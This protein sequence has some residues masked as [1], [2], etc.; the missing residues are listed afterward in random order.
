MGIFKLIWADSA[1][2]VQIILPDGVEIT[3]PYVPKAVEPF[4]LSEFSLYHS[5][6]DKGCRHE[7]K[8]VLGIYKVYSNCKHCGIGKEVAEGNATP[9]LG[10]ETLT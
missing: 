9:L 2:S 8:D 3:Y 6:I 7:W 1:P 5:L 10:K 4:E